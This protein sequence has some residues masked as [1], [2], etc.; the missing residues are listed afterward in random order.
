MSGKSVVFYGIETEFLQVALKLIEK[1]YESSEKCL[2]LC[3]N[4]EEVS[5]YDSKLWTYS[6]LNFIPHGNKNSL[7]IED[8]K[9]C[10][11]WLSTEIVFYNDPVCLLHN[12]LNISESQDI[13]KFQKIID[14][15]NIDLKS[16]AS[17]R[18]ESYKKLGFSE[19]KFWTQKEGSWKS[20]DLL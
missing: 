14:I 7:S 15:F 18:S 11:T 5:F 8:A 12:G 4:S 16:D 10:H 9:F 2:F 20:G 17:I 19:I 1:M 3:D 6:K 13:S